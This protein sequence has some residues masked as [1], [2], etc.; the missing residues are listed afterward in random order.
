MIFVSKPL[1]EEG[2]V[3]TGAASRPKAQLLLKHYPNLAQE[4]FYR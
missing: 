2:H 3:R 1:A 4:A